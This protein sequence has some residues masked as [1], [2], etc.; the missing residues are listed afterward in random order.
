MDKMWM[1]VIGSVVIG[2]FLIYPALRALAR[3]VRRPAP[4]PV[5]PPEMAVNLEEAKTALTSDR[6]HLYERHSEVVVQIKKLERQIK[7]LQRQRPGQTP[8]TATGNLAALVCDEAF[9]ML[10]LA[11]L[12]TIEKLQAHLQKLSAMI[13]ACKRLLVDVDTA[14]DLSRPFFFKRR[15]AVEGL[16]VKIAS[17]VEELQKAFEAVDKTTTDS[18]FSLRLGQ[19][20]DKREVERKLKRYEENGM[21]AQALKPETQEASETAPVANGSGAADSARKRVSDRLPTPVSNEPDDEEE[22]PAPSS[23]DAMADD[24]ARTLGLRRANGESTRSLYRRVHHCLRRTA[25]L[26]SSGGISRDV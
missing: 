9:A 26:A 17:A 15:G 1:V 19:P 5:Q 22:E 12:E 10:V 14:K 18:E 13:G 20:E 8:D 3:K 16:G 11:N 4:P 2:F 23:A 6:T 25:A 21:L 24:F 7:Q